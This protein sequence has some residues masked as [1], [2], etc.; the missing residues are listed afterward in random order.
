MPNEIKLEN[1][2]SVSFE[3]RAL[4]VNRCFFIKKIEIVNVC[5][6]QYNIIRCVG[7]DKILYTTIT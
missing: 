1:F 4:I 3:N 2:K 7:I 5:N 6:L